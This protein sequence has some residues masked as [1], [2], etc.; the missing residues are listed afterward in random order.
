MLNQVATAFNQQDYRTVAKLLQIWQQ[1]SPQDPWFKLYLGR[2][3]EATQHP[4][5]AEK[6]YRQLLQEGANPKISTQARQGLQRL[7][8]LPSAPRQPQSSPSQSAQTDLAWG[9][10][11]LEAVTGADR[12]HAVQ[13]LARVMQVDLYTAQSVIPSRGWRLYR[14]GAIADIQQVAHA[15]QS[16]GVATVWGSLAQ[17][18]QINV[19]QVVYFQ[20]LSPTPSVVCLNPAGQL[21]AIAFDWNEV[22]QQVAGKLPIF[23]QVVELGYRDRP[24]RK[25][26]IQDYAQFWDLHL[27]QRDCILRLGDQQYDFHQSVDFAQSPLGGSDRPNPRPHHSTLRLRWNTLLSSLKKNLPDTPIWSDFTIFAD[28]TADFIAPL[29]RIQPQIQLARAEST[30]WDAAFQLYSSLAFLRR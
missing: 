25:E 18:Q 28:T 14:A 20:A 12:R 22:Q 5:A 26:S 8:A 1:Q 23:E 10:L 9:F 27:P 17:L 16:A 21:G 19:F 15:L 29:E 24:E 13:T 7:A 11:A 30:Y 4:E 2:Y 3:Q 6:I